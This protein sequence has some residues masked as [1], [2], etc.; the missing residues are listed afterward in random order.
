MKRN[1]ERM[2]RF[3]DEAS[4]NLF[5]GYFSLVMATGIISGDNRRAS[6]A[7]KRGWFGMSD[8][9]TSRLAQATPSQCSLPIRA[10][11]FNNKGHQK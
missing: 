5:P 11:A 7:E 3:L 10:P 4:E 1:G 9:S 8:Y 2:K 6:V